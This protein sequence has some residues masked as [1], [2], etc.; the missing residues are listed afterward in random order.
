MNH[1]DFTLKGITDGTDPSEVS[2]PVVAEVLELFGPP[3]TVRKSD[4]PGYLSRVVWQDAV[5]SSL[6]QSIDRTV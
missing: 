3:A 6:T 2:N 1:A 4:A 5:R